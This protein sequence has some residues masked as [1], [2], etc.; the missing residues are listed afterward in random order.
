MTQRENAVT[1]RALV[2]HDPVIPLL[3][4]IPAC[5]SLFGSAL[6]AQKPHDFNVSVSKSEMLAGQLHATFLGMHPL[7]SIAPDQNG[8]NLPDQTSRLIGNKRHRGAGHP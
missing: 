7:G 4:L 5:N 6:K 2:S 3:P 8:L 1:V